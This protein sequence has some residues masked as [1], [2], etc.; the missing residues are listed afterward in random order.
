MIGSADKDNAC[1]I[2]GHQIIRTD[3]TD[4]ELENAI[5]DLYG[6]TYS[7]DGKR[8]LKAFAPLLDYEVPEGVEVIC[9]GAF[10]FNMIETLQ[11][12]DSLKAI[13]YN[14]FGNTN[15]KELTIPKNVCH[16]AT[17][18]PCATLLTLEKMTCESPHFV[19]ED[20]LL[21][22]SDHKIIYCAVTND[23]P[24]DIDIQE[25][26]MVIANG[27]FQDRDHL[28][29][30]TM[31]DTVL[32]IGAG[33]FHK[34][35]LQE[36]KLS[37]S[38]VCIPCDSFDGCQI[39]TLTIPEGIESIH[40]GAFG[41]NKMLEKALLPASMNDI[42]LDAFVDCDLLHEITA[43]ATSRVLNLRTLRRAG[44]DHHGDLHSERKKSVLG[45]VDVVT[46]VLTRRGHY[47]IVG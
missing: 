26:V 21:Y 2:T 1:H 18:N 8:L 5:Q 33:A 30:V 15:L 14:A 11:L 44:M 25:G 6:V 31:A 23:Y 36:L 40:N 9:N 28:H 4:K 43:P 42:E 19:V 47:S 32:Q 46:M 12:P 20:G 45:N 27:A 24:A 10:M 17:V 3:Y 39:V 22:T 37:K 16:I 7:K 13:G 34:S 29:S 38:L 35:A 41:N